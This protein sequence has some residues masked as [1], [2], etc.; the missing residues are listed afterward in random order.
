MILVL[1]GPPGSGKGT[2]GALLKQRLGFEH[3]STGD[4]LR[5]E[6]S[7]KTPLGLKAQEYMNQGLLVP[8]ELIVEMIKTLLSNAPDK[9]YVFDGFPRTVNQAEAFEAMLKTMNL[10]VDKVFYFD[11]DDDIIVKRL[12]GRRVCP[13]CGATYNI[14]YQKPKNDNLCDYD[15]TP[16]VQ[17][18]DDKEE[19]IINRL[20]VYKEQTSPLVEFY[21]NKNK[22]YVISALG[23]QE[24]VF[25]RLKSLL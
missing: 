18:E 8:D 12:S 19:V 13:K 24:E 22:L 5:S 10:D 9:N 1:L 2:Q 15:N 16:L 3:V 20:K 25:E 14:Y 21:K 11:L 4:M 7:K 17:R 23:S 6:V